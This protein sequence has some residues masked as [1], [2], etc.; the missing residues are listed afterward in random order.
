VGFDITFGIFVLAL[1][2]LAFL[3]LRWA[4]RHD[5]SGYAAWRKRQREAAPPVDENVPPT[6]NP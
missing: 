2:I 5:R 1:V 6:A 4:L 3:T